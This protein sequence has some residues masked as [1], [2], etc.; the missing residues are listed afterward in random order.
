MKTRRFLPML[1]SAAMLLIPGFARAAAP[2]VAKEFYV[3]YGS[4]LGGRRNGIS[5]GRFDAAT[6]KLTPPT[7]LAQA[8]GPSFLALS[9]DGRFLYACFE[10]S[11]EV[12]AYVV[13][14]A[15]GALSP[16]NIQPAGGEGPCHI[17]L[18]RTGKFALVANYGGGSV[19]V[20]PIGTSGALGPRTGFDQHTGSGPN[21]DRQ[22]GP[23]AHG[24]ITDPSNRFALCADLGNDTI[25]VYRFDARAGTLAPHATVKVAP[26]AGPRHVLFSPSG[27]ALFCL[28]ELDGTLTTFD[29][30]GDKGTLTKPQVTRNLPADFTA[31]N[32]NAELQLHPNGKFLYASARGHDA[33]AAFA[34]EAATSR[35]SLVQDVSTGGKTPRFFTFDPTGQWVICGNQ[36]SNT[37]TV[38]K[39]DATTGKLTAVGEPVA[40]TAPISMVFVAVP[41]AK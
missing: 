8:E 2:V 27:K 24:I 20:F 16:L 15:S 13:D 37:V 36:D 6:G 4:P 7:L 25:H 11:N 12:G 34:I 38:F 26:G 22:E 28:N 3:Y 41:T 18:D 19:A 10:G 31:F 32:K 35:V 40:A 17:S 23:H 14:A 5:L 21:R 9:A 29:W 30:D 39:A 1:A 33:I